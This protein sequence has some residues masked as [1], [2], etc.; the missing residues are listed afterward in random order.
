[1]GSSGLCECRE[2]GRWLT[3]PDGTCTC[4][5][6][7]NVLGGFQCQTCRELFDGCTS[8]E[9][10]DTVSSDVD[11]GRGTY[12]PLEIGYSERLS[13]PDRPH[14]YVVCTDCG[15][16]MLSIR[17]GGLETDAG[18]VCAYCD[19]VVTGCAKCFADY[20]LGCDTCKE[21]YYSHRE[22]EAT[23]CS[24]CTTWG[25]SCSQCTQAGCL[26]C[27]PGYWALGGACFKGLW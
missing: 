18:R 26:D 16:E 8:C 11:G 19:E 9:G 1:M 3:G 21:G 6:Y 17:A 20:T 15:D 24:T 22:G 12:R 4:S 27:G 7:V 5:E 10:T 14:H 25:T 23:V 13:N 2:E